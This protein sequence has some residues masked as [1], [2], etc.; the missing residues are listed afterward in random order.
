LPTCANLGGECPTP[1]PTLHSQILRLLG[2]GRKADWQLVCFLLVAKQLGNKNAMLGATEFHRALSANEPC[3]DL[4]RNGRHLGCN[5]R[6]TGQGDL[7]IIN[8]PAQRK[9]GEVLKPKNHTLKKSRAGALH[10][11]ARGKLTRQCRNGT[12]KWI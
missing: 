4:I 9:G 2:W 12:S 11:C 1:A 5:K 3:G 7:P 8:H 10:S 6:T